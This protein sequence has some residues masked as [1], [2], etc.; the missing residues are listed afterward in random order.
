M[1]IRAHSRATLLRI[2]CSRVGVGTSRC[3]WTLD[4]RRYVELFSSPALDELR[5]GADRRTLRRLNLPQRPARRID[6]PRVKAYS[7]PI[8]L[9]SCTQLAAQV[10]ACFGSL[11]LMTMDE[12]ECDIRLISGALCAL[13]AAGCTVAGSDDQVR[14]RRPPT[15][16]SRSRISSARQSAAIDS[17]SRR[18][19]GARGGQMRKGSKRLLCVLCALAAA[20]CAAEDSH[21][22][23]SVAEVSAEEH[24]YTPRVDKDAF[25]PGAR[26]VKAPGELS[27]QDAQEMTRA[28]SSQKDSSVFCWEPSFALLAFYEG[29]YATVDLGQSNMLRAQGLYKQEWE[30]FKLCDTHTFP[31]I[32]PY[33]EGSWGLRLWSVAAH[34]FVTVAL[35][36]SGSSYAQLVAR[37]DIAAEWEWLVLLPQRYGASVWSYAIKSSANNLLVSAEFGYS[38]SR[39]GML[40]ARA[41]QVAEWEYWQV[42]PYPGGPQF[43]CTASTCSV[44]QP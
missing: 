17:L 1:P 2:V 10:D 4:A 30:E 33:V 16:T 9:A 3:G 39:W 27:F 14:G 26:I 41:S 29:R 38:G 44:I 24:S 35:D 19:I 15:L 34:K 5:S 8:L 13:V 43:P 28:R 31:P 32:P 25:P 22:Q 11:Q 7:S 12:E 37:A 23:Q 21:E 40:R 18:Q 6:G 20:G 42:V 36:N